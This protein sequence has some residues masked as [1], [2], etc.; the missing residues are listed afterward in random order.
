MNIF[1]KAYYRTYQGIMKLLIPFMPYREP[2]ILSSTDDIP[3]VLIEKNVNNVIL[4]TDAGLTKLGLYNDL[5]NT[6]KSNNI[7]CIVFD[8]TVPNPTISNIEDAL[9]EYKK[10]HC[11]A[12][13]AFGGGSPM[14]CAKALGARVACPKKSV[15]KMK[16]LLKVKKELPLLIAVPTTAGTGSETTVAAVITDEKTHYKYAINDFCLIPK[17]AVLD[18]RL[19]IGLPKGV[20]S[21]TGLDALTHAIEAYIGRSSTKKTRKLSLEAI[22]TI[23]EN[24]KEVYDNPSNITAREKM[25][26]ASYK[27]GVAFTI[28][29]VGYVHAIAHSLG[30]KYGIAHGLANA[31]ILPYVLQFYGKSIYKKSKRICVYCNLAKN[32]DSEEFCFN[33]LIATILS[34]NEYMNIPNHIPE[35]N[36][37]DIPTLVNNAIKEA[38]PLYPVPRLA[39]KQQLS[40]LYYKIKG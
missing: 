30:G 25:L 32:T 24:I 36:S 12:I 18:A 31:I 27:A 23:F 37:D 13:I 35:I 38:N 28:S 6:L 34:Y 9:T 26:N 10:N 20:T 14:D 8:K 15:Q 2:Q 4:V 16:G 19:T 21:T 1:K 40:S 33:K 17:Y 3:H 29:Y 39:D 7:E 11:E 22:K 5:V